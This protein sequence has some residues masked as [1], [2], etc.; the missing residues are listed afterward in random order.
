MNSQ[1]NNNNNV[2]FSIDYAKIVA[3]LE[4]IVNAKHNIMIQ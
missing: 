1:Y 4:D 3:S 2:V